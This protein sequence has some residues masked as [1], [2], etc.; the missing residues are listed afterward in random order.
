MVLTLNR[1]LH[2]VFL[3][4]HE[5]LIAVFVIQQRRT[6]VPYTECNMTFLVFSLWQRAVPCGGPESP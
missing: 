1:W 6:M 2:S 5:T 4:R 3:W